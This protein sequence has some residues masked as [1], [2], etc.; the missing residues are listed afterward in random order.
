MRVPL[1][2]NSYRKGYFAGA[3]VAIVGFIAADLIYEAGKR[4]GTKASNAKNLQA[5]EVA[6]EKVSPDINNAVQEA[7]EKGF[8]AGRDEG[9]RI[10][11]LKKMEDEG[12]EG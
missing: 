6:L 11:S 5:F 1:D 8:N 4:D 2:F 7:Y 10:G 12:N 3:V 9:I